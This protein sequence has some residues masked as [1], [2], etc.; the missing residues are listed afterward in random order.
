MIA[1]H[2]GG[3]IPL[4]GRLFAQWMHHVYP[5]DYAYPHLSGTSNPVTAEANMDQT[6]K[7][8]IITYE[9]LQGVISKVSTQEQPET[10]NE[11]PWSERAKLFIYRR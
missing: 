5:R 6:V 10:G 9:G 3:K 2:Q 1:S 4:H 7:G 8:I 11:M